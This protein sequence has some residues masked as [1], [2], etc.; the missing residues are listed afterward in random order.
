MQAKLKLENIGSFRGVRERNFNSGLISILKGPAAS[1]KTTIIKSIALALSYPIRKKSTLSLGNSLGILPLNSN[2]PS[3]LLNNNENSGNILLSWDDNYVDL[4]LNRNGKIS[5][6]YNGKENFLIAA[7]FVRNSRIHESIQKGDSN[8]SWIVSEMSSAHQYEDIK[9]TIQSYLDQFSDAKVRI[10]EVKKTQSERFSA[11]EK[12]NLEINSLKMDLDRIEEE[13]KETKI[14][15]ALQEKISNLED[16]IATNQEKI[17]GNKK[18]LK[19]AQEKREKKQKEL[20][21]KQESLQSIEN[22]REE[23]KKTIEAKETESLE[24]QKLD[25]DVEANFQEEKKKLMEPLINEK[26]ELLTK[27]N[28]KNSVLNARFEEINECPICFSTIKGI[29]KKRLSD[30]IKQIEIKISKISQQ[31]SNFSD[32]IKESSDKVK[33]KKAT[34]KKL[35]IDIKD[36]RNQKFRIDS[37][38]Q[39]LPSEIESYNAILNSLEK[40]I[41]DVEK[42]NQKFLEDI[43]KL[44]EEKDIVME[45]DQSLKSMK[46]KKKEIEDSINEKYGR[47]NAIKDQIKDLGRLIFTGKKIELEKLEDV[48]KRIE[49]EFLIVFDYLT[50]KINEQ[51]T[52]AAIR[53]NQKAREISSELGLQDFGDIFI[54][55]KEFLLLVKRADGSE[56]P[57]SALSGAERSIIAALLQISCKQTYMDDIPFFIGDD[58]ILDLDSKLKGTFLNYMKKYAQENDSFVIFTMLP[59]QASTSREVELIEF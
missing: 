51:K 3:P 16:L 1:G 59:D 34:L 50:Q 47:I 29:D 5:S 38:I 6:N 10:S 18:S 37:A 53:F 41:S 49:P 27:K 23:L 40:N 57:L 11:I 21:E 14:D 39:A 52:G 32:E 25:E 17:A 55:P 19:D 2:D 12:S 45:Q 33:N 20:V 7:V 24:W 30:S 15:P 48:L 26:Q 22:E 54:D 44:K 4:K 42:I 43:K 31:I 8:F 13:I 35:A 56:L 46:D 28:L 36:F 58:S 9:E